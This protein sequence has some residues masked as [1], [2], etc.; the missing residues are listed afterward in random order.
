MSSAYSVREVARIFGMTESRVRYWAQTG[1]VNPSSW[2]GGNK[3][4]TFADLVEVKAAIGLLDAGVSLQKVRRSLNLLRQA[5]PKGEQSI[6]RLR[7]R[8]DGESLTVTDERTVFDALSG[9]VL[10][11]F[12]LGQVDRDVAAILRLPSARTTNPL[13]VEL[14][15]N[16]DG[17]DDG[18]GPAPLEASG[19][20]S[21]AHGFFVKGCAL[22]PI[23]GREAEAILAYEQ[24]LAADPGLAAAH[25]NLGNLLYRQDQTESAQQHYELAC[26]LDPNQVEARYNLANIH[27]ERGDVEM[28]IAEYRLALHAAPDFADA[29]FNLALTLERVGSRVQ[30][31]NHWQRFLDLCVD[32]GDDGRW[33]EVAKQHLRK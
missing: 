29:H 5:L 15:V 7:V 26:S 3:A 6:Q 8:G 18:R 23:P 12:D 33:L 9:Q 4:Y 14:S 30:A 21:S 22:D 24:A 17:T 25:T 13:P 16:P 19:E 32:D 1:I 31:R 20:P 27:E 11:D 10:I 28:A 2:Q